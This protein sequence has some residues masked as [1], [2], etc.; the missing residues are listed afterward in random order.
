M[1][2]QAECIYYASPISRKGKKKVFDAKECFLFLY[3]VNRQREVGEMCHS[4]SWQKKRVNKGTLTFLLSTHPCCLFPSAEGEKLTSTPPRQK[5]SGG[6]WKAEEGSLGPPHPRPQFR[7]LPTTTNPHISTHSPPPRSS[8]DQVPRKRIGGQE[9]FLLSYSPRSQGRS[10]FH[11]SSGISLLCAC[12]LGGGFFGRNNGFVIKD[13]R[14]VVGGQTF[15]WRGGGRQERQQHCS[16]LSLTVRTPRLLSWE[17]LS[18]VRERGTRVKCATLIRELGD[19]S[20][21]KLF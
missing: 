21:E 20:V 9:K 8:L 10:W 14:P 6:G 5:K 17:K 19:V 1:T 4:P 13:N 18:K 3:V 2:T 11:L 12:L 15:L 16:K 7:C